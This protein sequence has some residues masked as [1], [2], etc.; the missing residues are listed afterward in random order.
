LNAIKE[1]PVFKRISISTKSSCL[2]RSGN[3][4]LLIIAALFIF[5]NPSHAI[6]PLSE[7]DMSSVSGKSQTIESLLGIYGE[8]AAGEVMTDITDT[9]TSE[10]VSTVDPVSSNEGAV[11]DI[12]IRESQVVDEAIYDRLETRE[13][14]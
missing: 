11:V 1:T 12:D 4:K 8:P 13:F 14:P 2:L 10:H 7:I 3:R 9:E 5:G 6:Q